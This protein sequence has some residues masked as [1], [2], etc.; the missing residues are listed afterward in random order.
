MFSTY[1]KLEEAVRKNDGV[2]TVSM[3]DLKR[4]AEARRLGVHVRGAISLSLHQRGLEHSPK[5]LPAFQTELIRVYVPNTVVGQIIEAVES[6]SLE[7]DALLSKM[8]KKVPGRK[9]GVP[10]KRRKT[11]KRKV[12]DSSKPIEEAAIEAAHDDVESPD[13]TVEDVESPV[14]AAA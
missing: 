6:P 13:E 2:L 8:V 9:P 3:A 10:Q 4:V 14:G 12:T 1:E 7:G 11:R 5:M